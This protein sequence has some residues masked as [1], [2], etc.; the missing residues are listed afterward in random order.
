[1]HVCMYVCMYVCVYCVCMYVRVYVYVFM[2]VLFILLHATLHNQYYI[3]STY[4]SYSLLLH[5]LSWL[6]HNVLLLGCTPSCD[7]L[8]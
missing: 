6:L 3:I 7:R 2:Y 8:V 4:S 1:M 5:H